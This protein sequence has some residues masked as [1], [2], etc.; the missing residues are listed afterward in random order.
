MLGAGLTVIAAAADDWKP[1]VSVAVTLNEM[2]GAA[3]GAGVPLITPPALIE[4]PLDGG[5]SD[6][7]VQ[8]QENM[9]LSVAVNA[10]EVYATPTSPVGN[11]GTLMPLNCPFA[12]PAHTTIATTAHPHLIE[13]RAMARISGAG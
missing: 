12:A 3:E 7:Q 10:G 8:P 1:P 4:R 11:A 5:R 9:P 6:V 13:I 2:E